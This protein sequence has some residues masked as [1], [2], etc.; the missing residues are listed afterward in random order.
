MFTDTPYRVVVVFGSRFLDSWRVYPFRLAETK[1]LEDRVDMPWIMLIVDPL[2]RPLEYSIE[3]LYL[4]FLA[5]SVTESSSSI[6]KLLTQLLFEPHEV[7]SI[8]LA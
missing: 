5:L 8:A 7:R 3:I 2:R 6:L 4:S 1:F